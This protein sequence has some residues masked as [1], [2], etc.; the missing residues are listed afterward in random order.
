MMRW[1][2]DEDDEM[3]LDI[4][5]F[6]SEISINTYLYAVDKYLVHTLSTS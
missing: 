6:I 3:K 1:K 2:L 5:F 4:T